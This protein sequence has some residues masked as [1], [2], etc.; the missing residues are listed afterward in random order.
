MMH[1]LAHDH[2]RSYSLTTIRGRQPSRNR[3][4]LRMLLQPQVGA[5]LIMYGCG[6]NSRVQ[7]S[8]IVRTFDDASTGGTYVETRNSLYLLTPE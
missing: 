1:A 3:A 8:R 4:G 7:T 6:G 5:P 2:D